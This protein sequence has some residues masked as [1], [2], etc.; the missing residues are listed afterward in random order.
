[1]SGKVGERVVYQFEICKLYYFISRKDRKGA[2]AQRGF[3]SLRSLLLCG[4]CV[5]YFQN[6]TLPAK[7]LMPIILLKPFLLSFFAVPVP[8]VK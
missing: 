6:D 3:S 8:G 7:M 1:L 4:L 5:K 2:A